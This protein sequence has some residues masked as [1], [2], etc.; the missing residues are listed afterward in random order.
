MIRSRHVAVLA[1][2]LLLAPLLS[3]C[4]PN[5]IDKL[6]EAGGEKFVEELVEGQGGDDVQIDVGDEVSLPADWPGLPTPDGR[7]IS[8]M[9]SDETIVLS[10]E[11]ADAAAAS[12]LVDELLAAGFTETASADYGELVTVVLE[13]A[14]WMASAGWTIQ[15]DG[16]LLSYSVAPR[17]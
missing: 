14:E 10:Y 11:L 12:A 8:A 7:L 15:D 1:A 2:P 17:S 5:P 3:G 13:S 9:S 6:T 4:F 16:V